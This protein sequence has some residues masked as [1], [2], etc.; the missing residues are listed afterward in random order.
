MG[1]MQAM[2]GA[3]NAWGTIICSEGVGTIGPENIIRNTEHKL[4]ITIGTKTYVFSKY[5][6]QYI[7]IITSTSE[8]IKYLIALKNGKKYIAVFMAIAPSNNAGKGITASNT[9]NKINVAIQN[10][11]WWMFDLIYSSQNL[12]SMGNTVYSSAT[13]K[14]S[15]NEASNNTENTVNYENESISKMETV[16]TEENAVNYVEDSIQKTERTVMT[17]QKPATKKPEYWICKK[18]G[19]KNSILKIYCMSC[20]EYK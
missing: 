5:D 12:A 19:T 15:S 16:Y 14:P 10:F 13:I 2:K 20:G 17:Y 6:V 3:N 11:E 18:C 7:K 9:G 1:F 8:W 4:M